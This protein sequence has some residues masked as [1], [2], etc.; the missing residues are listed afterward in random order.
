M[1]GVTHVDDVLDPLE[2][3]TSRG[4]GRYDVF[5]DWVG[6]MLAAL[7]DDDETYLGILEDYDRG[8]DRDRGARN[9]DLFSHAFGELQAAMGETNRDVLGD[10]FEEFGMQSDQFGQHFTPHSVSH[11][12][13]E[14]QTS[15]GSVDDPPATV[16]DPACG[17][18][19][20]L[21]YTARRIDEPTVCFGQDKDELCAQMAAL[22]CCFFN[23]DAIVVYGDSLTVEKRRAWRTSGSLLGGEI[24]EVEPES[25][26]WPEA[27]FEGGSADPEP[28]ERVDV[29]TADAGDLEQSELTGW[30]A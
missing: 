12:L 18:G 24:A 10:A 3:I 7:Q 1:V 26:P 5:C 20:L 22:N 30:S 16:A 11:M 19:R 27:S 6:L 4:F 9:A 23:L 14:T 2:T 15:S 13:A 29:S 25:V 17:S 28:Q 8:R 21:I